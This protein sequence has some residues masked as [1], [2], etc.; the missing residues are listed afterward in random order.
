MDRAAYTEEALPVLPAAVKR[1]RP[2]GRKRVR[3]LQAS[4]HG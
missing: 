4:S 2:E 3:Q 1:G